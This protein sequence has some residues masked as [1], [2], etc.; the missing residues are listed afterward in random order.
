LV[1]EIRVYVEGGG[2]GGAG[3][4][5]IRRGFGR[6]LDPLRERARRQRIGW[7]VIACGS[8]QSTFHEFRLA[9]R[10]HPDAFNIL[11]VDAEEAV[12]GTPSEHLRR[13]QEWRD[14]HLPDDHVH[15]MVQTVEAWL[16]ADPEV[17][18]SFYG[19][20]FQGNALPR[21]SNVEEIDKDELLAALNHA[22]RGTRKGSYHKISYCAGLL[23]RMRPE[24]VRPRAP[25]CERLFA[26][27]EQLLTPP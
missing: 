25:H 20:G 23:A 21:R 26:S 6:F 2:D 11:L 15:L 12:S 24:R 1:R 19:Q 9:L 7:S 22:V 27:L 8:R 10:K 18:E 13:R 3:R 17:L 14:H 4:A 5:E 16:V